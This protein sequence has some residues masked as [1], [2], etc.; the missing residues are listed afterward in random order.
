MKECYE[1]RPSDMVNVVMAKYQLYLPVSTCTETYNMH[2][3][4]R[5]VGM[6]KDICRIGKKIKE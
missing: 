6:K 5:L 2:A 3:E 1:M 4:G